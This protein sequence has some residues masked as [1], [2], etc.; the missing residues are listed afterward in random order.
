MVVRIV[1]VEIEVQVEEVSIIGI[2]VLLNCFQG[3]CLNRKK[4]SPVG[5][6]EIKK[7]N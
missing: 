6:E 4:R 2:C 5:N 7:G 3:I 1:E